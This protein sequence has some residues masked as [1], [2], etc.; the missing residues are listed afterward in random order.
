MIPVGV[1][2]QPV[3]QRRSEHGVFVED[4]AREST[5]PSDN[6]PTLP[7]LSL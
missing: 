4:A 5:I 2:H 1:V 3:E 7:S 6:M